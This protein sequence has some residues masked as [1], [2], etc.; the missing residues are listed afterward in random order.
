LA[1]EDGRLIEPNAVPKFEI[2]LTL[3]GQHPQVRCARDSRSRRRAASGTGRAR[4]RGERGR[5][6]LRTEQ[7]SELMGGRSGR[8]SWAAS[9][10]AARRS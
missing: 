5:K 6:D 4:T 8:R 7:R 1:L 3:Q 2:V 10:E 9:R